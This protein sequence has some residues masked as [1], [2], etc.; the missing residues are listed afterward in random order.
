MPF[1]SHSDG[2]LGITS[3]SAPIIDS[4]KSEAFNPRADKK[5]GYEVPTSFRD[6]SGLGRIALDIETVDPGLQNSGSSAH[7]TEGKVVGVGI[8]YGEADAVYYPVG[9][10]DSSR[11]IPS[12]ERFWRWLKREAEEYRGEIVGANLQYD[13]DW[14]SSRHDVRF[15]N[16]KIRDVQTAEPLL[17]ETKLSYKLEVL[18]QEYLGEGKYSGELAERYGKDYIRHMDVVDPGWAGAYCE[19]DCILSWRILDKQLVLLEK[20]GLTD[21]FLMESRLTPLLLKMRGV[22]VKVDLATAE[23][24][25]EGTLKEA[26]EATARIK[27]MSGI[28]VNVWAN[29]SIAQ[30]MTRM[31]IDFPKTSKGA[32]S[33]KKEWLKQHPSDLCKE[34]ILVRE[35]EKTAGTFIKSYIL[36]NHINGRI[37][38]NFNQLRSDSS[39]TVS[40]RFSSSNPNLQNIP[41]RHPVLGPLCRSMF[42]PET[43]C[44]WGT[45]DWSQI[46]YR[47][48]VHYASITKGVDASVA[49][50]MY[51]EDPHTDFHEMAVALTGLPRKSAKNINF[52][53]VYGMGI[54][55]M[56]GHLGVSVE[57]ATRIMDQ[58]HE[59]VPFG[60]DMLE[61]ASARASRAG[62]IKTILGRKRRFNQWETCGQI[63]NSYEEADKCY[64]TSR[65]GWPPRRAKTH[66][67]LNAL[68]QG[69]AADLMKLSM[70]NMWE[71]GIFDVIPPHLTVHDEMDVSVP[72][73]KEGEEAFKEMVNIMENSLALQVPVKVEAATGINWSEAK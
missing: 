65:G 62:E 9:H 56:A 24:A 43:D 50:R 6:F 71:S 59:K 67:A 53:V 25:Y 12:P 61:V 45:A 39:G 55:A 37:H 32:P 68:L 22:G 18:A 40:G 7:G 72:Q 54:L 8:A 4:T 69:S 38:C 33:F 51:R 30:A 17:D 15:P 70:V 64:R 14:L 58:F 1:L 73:T 11:C 48:L 46:E 47:F 13:L 52:G 60:R 63:F 66:K 20:E 21:L 31:G 34:I 26:K 42:I 57:E 28:A 19:R 27:A 35:S 49:L 44:L 10:T 29:A 16:A 41:S 23:E 5:Q 36:E 3:P 2:K